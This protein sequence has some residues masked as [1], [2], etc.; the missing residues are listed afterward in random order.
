MNTED[1][2][3]CL[4]FI[5]EAERLKNVHRSAHTSTGKQESTAEHTWRLCLLAMVFESEFADIDFGKLL[6][7]CVVHDLGEAI[8]GD[9]PAVKQVNLPDKSAQERA[10]LVTLLSPLPQALRAQFL[11]LW[12]EYEAASSREARLAKGLD[13]IE[14]IIQHNQGKNPENFDYAF[15]LGYGQKQMDAHPLFSVIRR[16][17]DADTEKRHRES[18]AME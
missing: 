10:D 4:N 18:R 17:I 2:S 7:I 5:R 13:K 3:A 1:I 12:D 11:A 9:I 8:G 14:T 16:L 6:R 15:N